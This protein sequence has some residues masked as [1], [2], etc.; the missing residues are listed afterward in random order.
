MVRQIA[1]SRKVHVAAGRALRKKCPR[2]AHAG[3]V[4][5]QGERDPVALIEASNK[6][7]VESLVPVRHMRMLQS[8]F[9]FFRGAAAIQAYDLARTPATGVQVQACGDC[10]LMNFGGFATPERNRVFDVNDFDETFPAPWEWDVKRLAAS[11]TI[12]GRWRKFGAGVRAGAVLGAVGAYREWMAQ[13]SE[14]SVLDT[15]Y[16][17]IPGGDIGEQ[18]S[19]HAEGP[20]RIAKSEAEAHRRTSEHVFHS[21]TKTVRGRH[22]IVDQPPLLYHRATSGADFKR[23]IVRPFKKYRS[24]LSADRRALFDRWHL[25][26]IAFKVVGVGSVGTRCYIALFLADDDD[27]LFLQLKEARQS[28]LEPYVR[29]SLA[30]GNGERVVTGQRLMQ[31]ASDIFLG[32]TKGAQDRDFYVRQ[33][34]DMKV[35]VSLETLGPRAFKAYASLCGKTLA[36]AHAKAGDAATILGLPGGQA[37]LRQ[38]HRCLRGGLRGSDGARLSGLFEGCSQGAPPLC[39]PVLEGGPSPSGPR[40]QAP[41]SQPCGAEWS[42]QLEGAAFCRNSDESPPSCR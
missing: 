26:D 4:L 2:V 41:R 19:G 6:G 25:E 30:M 15:W 27:A 14:A 13:Y 38:S 32:W 40:K 18:F 20:R 24:T 34:R 1:H 10:H 22:Q 29:R 28:V 39:R 31:A 5:G 36:R 11:I 42:F 16:A 23:N 7:R 21:L 35:A 37:H 12:A 9:A 8:P 33:L 17:L 3:A